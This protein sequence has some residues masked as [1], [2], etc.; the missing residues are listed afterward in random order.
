MNTLSELSFPF[1]EA[2]LRKRYWLKLPQTDYIIYLITLT[3]IT[4]ICTYWL[5]Y[6]ELFL[7]WNWLYYLVDNIIHYK[8]IHD[9]IIDWHTGKHFWTIF[10]TQ[11][12]LVKERVVISLTTRQDGTWKKSKQQLLWNINI[13]H[14]TEGGVLRVNPHT[15]KNPYGWNQPKNFLRHL[16]RPLYLT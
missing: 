2:Y 12:E 1:N 9:H 13:R 10:G 4:L 11:T 5:T 8:I 3:I 7:D 16:T 15:W 6:Q 14:V